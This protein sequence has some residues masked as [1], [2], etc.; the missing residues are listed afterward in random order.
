MG[1][2]HRCWSRKAESLLAVLHRDSFRNLKQVVLGMA[3]VD[4]LDSTGLMM[5][6]AHRRLR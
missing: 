5:C 4:R 3:G 6:K 1:G 2:L